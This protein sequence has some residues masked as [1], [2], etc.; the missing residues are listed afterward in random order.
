M[1]PSKVEKYY[2]EE[3]YNLLLNYLHKTQEELED[4]Y[5]Q[6][7]AKEQQ[8]S[9]E[10]DT[11]KKQQAQIVSHLEIELQTAYERA[12]KAEK[13]AIELANKI[14]NPE[15]LI[16]IKK[17]KPI[18]T[19]KRLS[20][21]LKKSNRKL[22]DEIRLLLSSPLFDSKWYVEQYPDVAKS[23]INPAEHYLLYG[24][25][26]GRQPGPLFNGKKYLE[27]YPDVADAGL[28]P[29]LHFILFGQQEGRRYE[30]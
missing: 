17:A 24:A 1:N 16:T 15:N 29:L 8:H 18:E 23:K 10:I 27:Q 22:S 3:E 14:N 20:Q 28:N 11:L 9:Q 25:A 30:C 13:T 5:L 26:E 6:L 7:K 21:G 19:L 12:K 4:Y 2:S